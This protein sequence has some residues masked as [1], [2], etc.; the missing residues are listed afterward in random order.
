MKASLTARTFHLIVIVSFV[1][2]SFVAAQ[3]PTYEVLA[4]G[5]TNGP[6][7]KPFGGLVLGPDGN[8]YGTTTE[9]GAF[10][11]GTVFK[12]TPQGVLST[13]VSFPHD[14]G[15][16]REALIV[17]SDGNLYGAT[18]GAPFGMANSKGTVFCVTLSGQLTTLATF[19]NVG[20]P[21]VAPQKLIQASD[22]NFYGMTA[23][24][25]ADQRGSVFRLSQNGTLTTL[26]SFTGS[27]GSS[28]YAG[29]L[30]GGDGNLYGTTSVGGANN[31]GIVFRVT[32]AGVITTLASFQP[33]TETGIFP[34]TEL[35]LGPDGNFYGVTSSQAANSG[36]AV[37]RITPTGTLTAL[38]PL[39]SNNLAAP[40]PLILGDDGKFLWHHGGSLL[41]RDAGGPID[42]AHQFRF[43][44]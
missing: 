13:L 35:T 22:G 29:L 38:A 4:L 33:G 24:G 19:V 44:V 1:L 25:G 18:E 27:N 12:L 9:G 15:N 6:G 2:G 16:P 14:E 7:A 39:P 37:F 8:Y 42:G 36:G 17:G 34:V 10:A 5:G 28:P 32:K 3:Q 26:L 31:N 30:E 20:V 21:P 40:S 23:A 43:C 11:G 41:P